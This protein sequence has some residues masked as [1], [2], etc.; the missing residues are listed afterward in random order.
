MVP[1]PPGYSRRRKFRTPIASSQRWD[2]HAGCNYPPQNALE[3]VRHVLGW[4]D[5]WTD[6]A[7][8]ADPAADGQPVGAVSQANVTRAPRERGPFSMSGTA[9]RAEARIAEG[10]SEEGPSCAAGFANRKGIFH[11]RF[12]ALPLPK[13]THDLAIS[14]E[15]L[16]EQRTH[17]TRR[18]APRSRVRD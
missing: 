5:H 3:E 18:P 7:D 10:P 8:P 6:P 12:P 2:W 15:S 13:P 1:D 14:G 17:T 16:Y 11:A 4:R 9:L